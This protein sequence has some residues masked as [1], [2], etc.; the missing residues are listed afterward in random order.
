VGA[1]QPAGLLYDAA[2][3]FDIARYHSGFYATMEN[4]LFASL[5]LTHT[6]NDPTMPEKTAQ[7]RV[8]PSSLGPAQS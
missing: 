5:G 8:T 1:R 3:E 6:E 2:I 4:L 7:L